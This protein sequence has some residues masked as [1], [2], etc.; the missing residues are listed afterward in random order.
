MLLDD[1]ANSGGFRTRQ[2]VPFH[3]GGVDLAVL[4]A[5][6]KEEGG[7]LIALQEKLQGMIHLVQEGLGSNLAFHGPLFTG[8]DLVMH[9]V[10]ELLVAVTDELDLLQIGAIRL[11]IIDLFSGTQ[12]GQILIGI[13]INDYMSQGHNTVLRLDKMHRSL[14]ELSEPLSKRCRIL[15]G[16]GQEDKLHRGGNENHRLLPDLATIGIVDE[17]AFVK[18]DEAQVVEG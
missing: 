17:V 12:N 1:R 15:K 9:L 8:Q 11:V 4:A 7:E 10:L 2:E 6:D 16:C 13:V 18:D 5:K 3:L 14:L